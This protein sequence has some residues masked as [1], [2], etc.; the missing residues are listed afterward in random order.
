MDPQVPDL[1]LL[2]PCQGIPGP[3]RRCSG[4]GACEVDRETPA[5]QASRSLAWLQRLSAVVTTGL[6]M[7]FHDRLK[8]LG[9]VSGVVFAVLLG[10]QQLGVLF[11]LLSKNT[12]FVENARAQIW[13]APPGTKLFQSGRQTI[14]RWMLH[15]ARG[16]PGVAR[17]EPLLVAAGEL[18]KPQGGGEPVTIVG[19]RLPAMLGGPW[20]VVAGS[21]GAIA[22]PDTMVFE[23]SLRSKYGALNLHSEREVNGHRILVGGFTW[24]LQPFGP[25]YAFAEIDLARK[26]TE[27]PED[28]SSFVLIQLRD[29]ASAD[30]VASRLRRRIPTATIL[31]ADQFKASIQS[32]LLREQLGISFGT[33]TSFGLLVG[34]VIV[35]L[36]MFSSV[37]DNQR[38]LGTLKALGWTNGDLTRMLLTQSLVYALVGSLAGL[39]L[40][41]FIAEGIRTPQLAVIV[42]TW[43]IA[44]VPAVMVVVCVLASTLALQR[45]RKLEPGEVFK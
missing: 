24:G 6:A 1:R 43:L 15:A 4:R 21:P 26:L 22:A 20:N 5:R 32:A 31:T 33:S 18:A 2:P 14:P 35:A 39:G 45:L 25:A 10:V 28:Q 37:I 40:V 13:I 3:C 7:M 41:T 19:T 44:L 11:G 27:M 42:P 30:R 12:M 29:G 8:F 16:T 23:D 9:T 36:S 34:F 38:E 17:A